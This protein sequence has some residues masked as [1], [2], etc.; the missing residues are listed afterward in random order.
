M[1][2]IKVSLILQSEP[3]SATTIQNNVLAALKI[4]VCT[5]LVITTVQS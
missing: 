3:S 1:L 2:S 5:F 4:A